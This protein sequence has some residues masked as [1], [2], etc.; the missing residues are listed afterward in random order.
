MVQSSTGV[1]LFCCL[2]SA[3]TIT[4]VRGSCEMD[5]SGDGCSDGS[6]GCW[7][8]LGDTM[9]GRPHFEKVISWGIWPAVIDTKVY[10]YYDKAS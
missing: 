9:D 10:L 8:Y 6:D 2:L 5:S 7:D 1:R 3:T 4:L